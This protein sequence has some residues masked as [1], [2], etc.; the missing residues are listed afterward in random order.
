M[1]QPPPSQKEKLQGLQSGVGCTTDRHSSD[2]VPA[3]RPWRRTKHQH[4]KDTLKTKAMTQ[5]RL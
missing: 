3:W 5:V 4:S 1:R 2:C